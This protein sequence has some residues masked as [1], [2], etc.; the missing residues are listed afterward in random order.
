MTSPSSTIDDIDISIISIF[1][2]LKKNDNT[3]TWEIAKKIFKKEFDGNSE[4][5]NGLYLRRCRELTT[6]I[7]RRI[8]K[9]QGYGIFTTLKNSKKN[10]YV[11]IS[12][13]VLFGKRK[14]PDRKYYSCIYLKVYG[15]WQCYQV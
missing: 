14:F 9:M 13:E 4:L 12:D 5:S 15:R 2:H 10:I 6:F 11:L 1:Y 3:T 7:S 8:K